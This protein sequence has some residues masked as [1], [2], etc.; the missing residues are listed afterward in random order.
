MRLTEQLRVAREAAGITQASVSARSGIAVTNL[1]T[2]EAG[3]VDVR[4]S[5]LKRLLDALD[6]EV[7][8]VPRDTPMTLES[9]VVQSE[10]GRARLAA[11]G[12]SPSNP[13]ER[14]NA[15]ERQGIDVS[16]ERELLRSRA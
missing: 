2:I 15:K 14:L 9:A 6:L 13:H 1:S 3:K 12:L 10:R 5:T 11:A 8:L 7:Q 4:L 16:V